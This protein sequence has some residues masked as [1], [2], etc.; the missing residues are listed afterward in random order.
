MTISFV[1]WL[2]MIFVPTGDLAMKL[3]AIVLGGLLILGMRASWIRKW[4]E[5]EEE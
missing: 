3:S 1:M 5:E 2:P 4:K